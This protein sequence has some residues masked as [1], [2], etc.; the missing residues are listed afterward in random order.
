M[1]GDLTL[2]VCP[3]LR[4]EADAAVAEMEGVRVE[5]VP[6]VCD[7]RAPQ[8]AEL[9]RV[10]SARVE[11]R[12]GGCC[13]LGGSCLLGVELP[14]GPELEVARGP[15]CFHLLANRGLVDRWIDEGA[16]L[17]TPGWLADWR[18]ELAVWGLDRETAG[19]LFRDGASRLL[20]VDTG[21][22]PSATAQLPE[23]ADYLNLPFDVAPVGLDH[24]QLILLDAVRRARARQPAGSEIAAL[25]RRLAD[26]SA[27]FDFT[28]RLAGAH[29]ESEVVGRLLEL[30][31]SLLAPELLLYC[32]VEGEVVGPARRHP[33]EA[34]TN[35]KLEEE[36]RG[37]RAETSLTAGG[38]GI[39]FRIADQRETFGLVAAEG[40]AFPRYKDRYLDLVR[41]L[42]RAGA[43]ALGSV[44]AVGRAVRAEALRQ[45]AEQGLNRALEDVR[46][47]QGLLPICANCKMIKGSD[48]SWTQI[49]QYVTS[50]SSAVFSHGLCPDCYS[51]LYP[52]YDP[53]RP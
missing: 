10:V 4:L 25:R 14:K 7:A 53:P 52:D 26:G 46:T 22:D 12:G 42:A 21:V 49:E 36:L 17:L 9:G 30:A 19:A 35:A 34:R 31:K 2:L 44:R 16:H 8:R 37:L 40:L 1:P 18:T 29:D 32:P 48:G 41:T 47:L 13:L 28:A 23:L 38:D 11:A 15:T 43:V 5:T 24:F 39:L 33:P 3:K 27:I 6:A 50:H 51:K 20:L 45:Q